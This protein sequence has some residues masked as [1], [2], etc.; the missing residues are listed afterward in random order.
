MQLLLRCLLYWSLVASSM[1]SNT[2][3][4]L[5]IGVVGGGASGFMASIS[6]GSHL[7]QFKSTSKVSIEIIESSSKVLQK[8]LISGGGRCNVCHDPTK[9]IELILQGYPRGSKQLKSPFLTKF[10]PLDVYNWF[11][12]R[13]VSLKTEADGRVFPTSDKSETIANALLK[14][15]DSYGISIVMN[16]KVTDIVQTESLG[17]QLTTSNGDTKNYDYVVMATGSSKLVYK[18]MQNLNHKIVKP[19][20]SLFSFKVSPS[21][22]C[23]T[24]LAGVSSENAIVNIKFTPEEKKSL[25]IRPALQKQL[26]QSGPL[27]IT[28]QG[29]SGPAILKLSAFGSIILNQINYNF[30]IEIE[31]IMGL[32]MEQ[33]IDFITFY[34]ANKKWLNRKVSKFFPLRKGKSENEFVFAEDSE[35]EKPLLTRRLW[36]YI[37]KR[38]EISENDTYND[39]S[40][41]KIRKIAENVCKMPFSITGKGQYRDE[42]VTA[43]GVSLK[44]VNF[45]SYESKVCSNLYICGE[46]LD[47]DGITGGY[48]FQNAWTS[49]YIAGQAICEQILNGNE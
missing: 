21:Y 28:H 20:P 35:S 1:A 37:L 14:E 12:S 5:R 49:G 15:A 36:N 8:V 17:F 18:L 40:L 9:S 13:G 23:V 41:A 24:E 16:Q 32:K 30:D 38:S 10:A 34:K 31:W 43:G 29:F 42:F 19:T 39:L 47:V 4:M 46:L 33:C 3:R 11:E 6:L 25:Q 44:D 2:A 22:C 27:L 48:N 45:N 7:S 26:T